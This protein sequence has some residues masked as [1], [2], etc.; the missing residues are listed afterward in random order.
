MFNP[1]LNLGT[2]GIVKAVEG[3]DKVAGDSPDSFKFNA[4][5]Y[6]ALGVWF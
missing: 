4:Y 1:V 6:K 2:L 5:P 3:T